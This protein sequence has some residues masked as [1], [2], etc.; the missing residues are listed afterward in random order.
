MPWSW[1]LETNGENQIQLRK[2]NTNTY[3]GK[4]ETNQGRNKTTDKIEKKNK[5]NM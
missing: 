4:T 1:D 5:I 3:E 2:S